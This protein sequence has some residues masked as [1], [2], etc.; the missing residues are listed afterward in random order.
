MTGSRRL[1]PRQAAVTNAITAAT[2]DAN[3]LGAAQNGSPA[4]LAQQIRESG[5]SDAFALT[6]P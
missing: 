3:I 4:D 6:V 5:A 1:Q 2:Y